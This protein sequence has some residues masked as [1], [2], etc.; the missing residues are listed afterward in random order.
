VTG[1]TVLSHEAWIC[2]AFKPCGYGGNT[3][4]PGTT[5]RNVCLTPSSIFTSAEGRFATE[6]PMDLAQ[7][8]RFRQGRSSP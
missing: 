6:D 2:T 3:E 8:P 4:P 5:L 1:Q 7:P